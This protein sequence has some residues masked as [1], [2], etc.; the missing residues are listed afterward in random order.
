M[1]WDDNVEPPTFARAGADRW[2]S[3]K[4]VMNGAEIWVAFVK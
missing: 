1:V 3:K 4:I 2:I